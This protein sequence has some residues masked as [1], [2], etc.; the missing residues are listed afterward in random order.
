MDG[1][2]LLPKILCTLGTFT[3]KSVERKKKKYM[4]ANS[5]TWSTGTHQAWKQPELNV[6]VLTTPP[7]S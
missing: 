4:K 3:R 2:E 5:H 7:T 1:E 6:S